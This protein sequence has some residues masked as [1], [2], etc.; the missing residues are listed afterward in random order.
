MCTACA[1]VERDR[2]KAASFRREGRF[3]EAERLER[4]ALDLEGIHEA[5]HRN[6]AKLEMLN[7][8][9]ERRPTATRRTA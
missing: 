7:H 5:A 2:Q 4:D 8:W 3:R 9:A 6:T 1:M